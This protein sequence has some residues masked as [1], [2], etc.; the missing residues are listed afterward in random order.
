MGLRRRLRMNVYFSD[1]REFWGGGRA[2]AI[3]SFTAENLAAMNASA[4]LNPADDIYDVDGEGDGMPLEDLLLRLNSRGYDEAMKKRQAGRDRM[5]QQWIRAPPA[6]GTRDP[7]CRFRTF[8]GGGTGKPP[9]SLLPYRVSN[10]HS[11][12]SLT[13]ACLQIK[14]SICKQPICRICKSI[15]E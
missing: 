11:T 5:V 2:G 12:Y 15:C 3:Q 4:S 8:A 14:E 9:L 13:Y 6:M 7:A 10:T 1:G